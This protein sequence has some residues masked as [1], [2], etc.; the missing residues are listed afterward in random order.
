MS[1]IFA[2]NNR[3]TFRRIILEFEFVADRQK[4]QFAIFD[5]G[6]RYPAKQKL[7][8]SKGLIGTPTIGML[9]RHG[10]QVLL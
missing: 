5:V 7:V 2:A 6:N 9:W 1:A 10:L 4:A 3:G 8:G